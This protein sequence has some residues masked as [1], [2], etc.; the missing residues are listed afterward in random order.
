MKSLPFSCSKRHA[1][2]SL[3]GMLALALT[4]QYAL[5]S[6]SR[7]PLKGKPI[8]VGF[9]APFTGPAAQPGKD[10]LNGFKLFLKQQHHM[11]E[12]RPVKLYVKDTRA[13][14]AIA[15]SDLR[16][17][18]TSDHID[19]LMGP[20][21][22]ASGH[23]LLSYINAHKIPTIYPIVSGESITQ[24][25]MSRY[26]IRTGWTSSQVTQPFGWYAYHKLGYRRIATLGVAYSFGYGIMA[27]FRQTF[28]A[29]GG[30]VVEQLW[31]PIGQQDFSP[32]ISKLLAAKPQAV[33]FVLLGS[34]AV[35]FLK[36]WRSLGVKI[37]L[38]AAGNDTDW[39]VLPS[40]GKTALGI[41][42]AL[43]FSASRKTKVDEQFVAAYKKM[44]HVPP[45]YYSEG[46]YTAGLFLKK[47]VQAVG[48]DIEDKPAFL[49]ALLQAH[50]DAPRGK[51]HLGPWQNP[52]ENV[53]VMRVTQHDG[54]LENKVIYTFPHVT[55]FWKYNPAWFLSRPVYSKEFPP[56]NACGS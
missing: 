18:Y 36:Q 41:T 46:T 3:V 35:R 42:T 38:L 26:I 21:T 4:T 12:G 22:A 49:N 19:V 39:S 5:A 32:Y 10:M 24:K 17:L 8:R 34:D 23:A 40:E 6:T 13:K 53:Y 2:V 33:M 7:N 52:V 28:Q 11:L 48:G 54:K 1:L 30:K 50:V 20:L 15:L 27:G 55:Q 43:H 25:Q 16:Q 9:L 31:P 14:P 51:V 47:A 29:A 56:C 37:P 45:A 44:F